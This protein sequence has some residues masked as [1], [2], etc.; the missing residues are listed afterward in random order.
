LQQLRVKTSQPNTSLL[1]P[2]RVPVGGA[3]AP[4]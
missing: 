3:T 2:A 1:F 4:Q